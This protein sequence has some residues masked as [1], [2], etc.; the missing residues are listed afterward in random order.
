MSVLAPLFRFPKR[1]SCQLQSIPKSCPEQTAIRLCIK[2][3]N[4]TE[5]CGFLK[6]ASSANEIR[7]TAG[8]R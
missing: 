4:F 7:P 2:F 8:K 5:F 1:A 6:L 3:P